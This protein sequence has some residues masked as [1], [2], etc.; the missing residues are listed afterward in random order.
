MQE[1][2]SYL[3][4]SPQFEALRIQVKSP[5]GLW[6]ALISKTLQYLIEEDDG[7]PEMILYSQERITLGN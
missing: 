5:K 4:M 2:Y 7:F 6:T 3:R 1:S